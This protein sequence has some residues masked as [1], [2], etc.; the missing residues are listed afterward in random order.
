MYKELAFTENHLKIHPLTALQISELKEKGFLRG[1]ISDICQN[2]ARLWLIEQMNLLGKCISYFEQPLV[3]DVRPTLGFDRSSSAGDLRVLPHTDVAWHKKP[4]KFIGFFCLNPGEEGEWQTISDSFEIID[5]LP[6]PI[7]SW[8]ETNSIYFPTPSHVKEE[9]FTGK[10]F[11]K[12]FLRLNS[13]SIRKNWAKEAEFFLQKLIE[14][15]KFIECKKGDFWF[16]DNTRFAHGRYQLNHNT[17]R[18][19]LRTYGI[20]TL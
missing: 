2:T 8:L 4:P 19:L 14:V 3:M 15:E 12:K 11:H 20:E 18:H 17:S 16:I 1:S 7:K 13:R 9:G 10:I 5:S 6:R